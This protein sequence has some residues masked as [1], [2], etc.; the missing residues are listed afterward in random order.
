[1]RFSFGRGSISLYLEMDPLILKRGPLTFH[2][3]SGPD[4]EV[5]PVLAPFPAKTGPGCPVFLPRVGLSH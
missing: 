4:H 1:M 5:G 2:K 3:K